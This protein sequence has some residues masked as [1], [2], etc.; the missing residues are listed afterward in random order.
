MGNESTALRMRGAFAVSFLLVAVAYAIRAQYYDIAS[1]SSGQVGSWLINYGGGFVRR[2]L[3]GQLFLW[4]TP[5]GTSALWILLAFQVGCYLLVLTVFVYFL[6]ANDYSWSSIALACGPAALPFIAWDWQGGFR[7]ELLVFVALSLL[8]V[9][10]RK[11]EYRPRTAALACTAVAVFTLAVFS[12]EPSLLSAPAVIY[13]L[14]RIYPIRN[15]VRDSPGVAIVALVAAC[16]LLASIAARGDAA[17]IDGIYRALDSHGLL[18]P[19]FNDSAVVSLG[20]T[21]DTTPR[22][23]QQAFPVALGFLPLGAL[24]LLP[25]ITNPWSSRNWKWALACVIGIL[26]LF[27]IAIDY[28]RFIHLLVMELS[29]C[30]MASGKTLDG[31]LRWTAVPTVIYISMWGVP[32]LDPLAGPYP[33]WFGFASTCVRVATGQ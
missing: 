7:Q 15:G 11:T 9:A 2:G 30:I 26:P 21:N 13:L 27:F 19:S 12:W 23:L 1:G 16:G 28:G 5:H 17:T 10:A 29:L 3:F 31:G 24:A 8:V 25:A 4:L 18:S 6:H 32:Y 14:L 33:W 22:L 20:W